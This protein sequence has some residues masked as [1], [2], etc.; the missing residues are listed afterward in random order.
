MRAVIDH[1]KR[2]ND[3]LGQ[4]AGDR[5][6]AMFAQLLRKHLRSEDLLARYGSEEFVMLLAGLFGRAD[7]ALYRRHGGGS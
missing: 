6:L 2:V 5:A 7:A 3:T 1:S 4:A